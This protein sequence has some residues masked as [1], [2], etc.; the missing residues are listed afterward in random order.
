MY[1]FA[2]DPLEDRVNVDTS[3]AY[4]ICRKNIW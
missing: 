4:D 1:V 3:V 2:L